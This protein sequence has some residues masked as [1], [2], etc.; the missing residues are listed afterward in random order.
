MQGAEGRSYSPVSSREK[1]LRTASTTFANMDEEIFGD[2]ELPDE[3][4]TQIW[5]NENDQVRKSRSNLQTSYKTKSN[6]VEV[7]ILTCAGFGS[8]VDFRNVNK[9]FHIND[10]KLLYNFISILSV[11][12]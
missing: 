7:K 10:F 5:D 3:D 4:E 11:Y 6:L 2:I 9:I 8:R 1:F 12:F